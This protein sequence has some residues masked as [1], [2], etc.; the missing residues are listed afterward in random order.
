MEVEETLLD[1]I[2][3]SDVFFYVIVLLGLGLLIVWLALVY[4][5][6]Q[7][8]RQ[9]YKYSYLWF[10]FSG[11]V[12]LTNILGIIFYLIVRPTETLEEKEDRRL[13]RKMLEGANDSDIT[14][15]CFSCEKHFS[16]QF[17]FCPHCKTKLKDKCSKCQQDFNLDHT[18][19]P[20]CGDRKILKESPSKKKKSSIK[21]SHRK[22]SES[23]LFSRL[24][25][26]IKKTK[27][28]KSK[29]QFSSDK[30]QKKNKQKS[31]KISAKGG[32]RFAGK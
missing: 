28:T 20:Y 22:S 19:C 18:F 15:S 12:L 9:R 11:I 16:S 26:K 8:A 32:P 21:K 24:A 6:F 31:K 7:D 1:T 30:K 4:W 29:K 17:N 3:N 2:I 13:E 10:I 23:T 5:I 27:Q 25:K 14:V